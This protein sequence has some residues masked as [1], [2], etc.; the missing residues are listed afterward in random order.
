MSINQLAVVSAEKLGGKRISDSDFKAKSCT[1]SRILRL[2]YL[3]TIV[4]VFTSNNKLAAN[5]NAQLFI[6][7]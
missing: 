5:L 6:C 4:L 1:V 3:D 7:C 2:I